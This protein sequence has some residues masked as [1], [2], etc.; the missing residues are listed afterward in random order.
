MV[1]DTLKVWMIRNSRKKAWT[2]LLP[3]DIGKNCQEPRC[4]SSLIRGNKNKAMSAT[5]PFPENSGAGF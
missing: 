5:R 2:A 4:K 3:G 1:G